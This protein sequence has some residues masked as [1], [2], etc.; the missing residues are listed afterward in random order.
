M[1]R[2][3]T[4]ISNSILRAIFHTNQDK[5]SI[6]GRILAFFGFFQLTL[7]RYKNELFNKLRDEV[8][9]L[10]EDEYRESFRS[11]NKKASLKAVGDLGYSG[12]VGLPASIQLLHR[13]T[14]QSIVTIIDILHNAQ[15]QIPH[16]ISPATLRI[17][18]LRQ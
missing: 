2:R 17:Q 13:C 10:D 3:D 8:W 4:L 1:G 16:K 15:L 5:K 9:E 14:N 7:I 6:L 11:G 18:L 12:S